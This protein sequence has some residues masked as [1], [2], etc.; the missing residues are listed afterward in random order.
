M[1]FSVGLSSSTQCRLLLAEV[2]LPHNY[3]VLLVECH[4]FPLPRLLAMRSYSVSNLSRT[5][6]FVSKG[7]LP[8]LIGKSHAILSFRGT[9]RCCAQVL[10]AQVYPTPAHPTLTEEEW[11]EKA[12]ELDY[13][14][15]TYGKTPEEVYGADH[16]H[17]LH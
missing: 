2:F 10:T 12:E 14:G 3:H 8:G 17:L 13:D 6:G 15:N 7:I 4:L 11:L 16:I 9:L 5:S 1:L